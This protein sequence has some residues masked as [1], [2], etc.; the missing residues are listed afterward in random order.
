MSLNLSSSIAIPTLGRNHDLLNTIDSLLQ[1]TQK[2]DEL[3]IIDQNPSEIPKLA[4]KLEEAS[5]TLSV[6][7]IKQIDANLPKARNN[8]VEHCSKDI[9]IFIDDDCTLAPQFIEA[10]LNAHKKNQVD[11]VAG[12][13]TNRIKYKAPQKQEWAPELAYHYFD[14]DQEITHERL[15]TFGGGNHSIRPA[16]VK[17]MGGYDEN[18]KGWALREDS[19]MALRLY[20]AGKNIVFEAS[21]QL[22]H[23][24]ASTGGCRINKH[25]DPYALMH[26]EI[27]F[28]QKHFKNSDWAQLNKK[29]LLKRKYIYN[30]MNILSPLRLVKFSKIYE[31]LWRDLEN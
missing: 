11:A 23:L 26:P 12:R 10:H 7:H 6:Q 5:K 24:A 2:P 31:Q 8:A 21:A 9:I 29:K 18:F 17:E 16:L 20:K 1:C 22:N 4:E 14:L 19:D 27:Y 15:A 30:K 13:I 28:I 3:I 25:T